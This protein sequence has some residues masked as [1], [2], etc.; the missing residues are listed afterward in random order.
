MAVDKEWCTSLQKIKKHK[1]HYLF[2][3]S[4]FNNVLAHLDLSAQMLRSDWRIFW[5]GLTQADVDVKMPM[6][7]PLCVKRHSC[8]LAFYKP[9]H[10]CI[11][12]NFDYFKSMPS[13]M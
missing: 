8:H 13:A 10:L 5:R 12:L 9:G 6:R 1:T 11:L 3:T 2:R 7:T 4:E